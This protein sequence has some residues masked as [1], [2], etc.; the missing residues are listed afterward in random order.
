MKLSEMMRAQPIL[1]G[2]LIA[3]SLVVLIFVFFNLTASV[4]QNA[5]IGRL[6]VGIVNLDEG[7]TLPGIGP[8]HIADQ[9]VAALERQLPLATTKLP[10][11]ASAAAALER[12]VIVAALILPVDF[13]R[14]VATGA[15]AQARVLNSDHLSALETQVG[16]TVAGQLQAALTVAVLTART[17]LVARQVPTVA[18]PGPPA[19]AAN[20]NA[21][22]AVPV[23]PVTVTP[24]EAAPAPIPPAVG[25]NVPPP[26]SPTGPPVLVTTTA[27][28]AASNPVLLQAPFV[29]SFASWMGSLIGAILLFFGTRPLLRGGGATAS[30]AIARTMIPLLATVL[31]ALMGV[32]LVAWLADAWTHFWELWAFRWLTMAA[33]MATMTALFS[34]FGVLAFFVAVP[35]VFYQSL[36]AGLLAPPT[37]APE[38]L[39]WAA[40]APFHE[41]TVALRSLLIG[42]PQNVIPWTQLGI[43]LG[44][45]IVAVWFGTLL[46]SRRG[47]RPA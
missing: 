6:T 11:E 46:W 15:T 17:Q 18:P 28:F 25:N 2:A 27:L 23:P 34:L 4:D 43:V 20:P 8:I 44:V 41:T 47:R 31:A 33:I 39:A 21:V 42:G 29:L 5:L 19:T 14:T 12:G 22:P 37:A 35:L 10:D 13:S 1:R 36:L 38:W 24:L 40:G 45:A 26:P 32:L 30:V 16:R 7:V 3:P 9:A